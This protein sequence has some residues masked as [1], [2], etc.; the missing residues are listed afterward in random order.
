MIAE[1]DLVVEHFVAHGTHRGSV[2]GESPTGR[3]VVLRGINIFRIATAR[4]P[5]GGDGSTILGC[6]S[7]DS[8][9]HRPWRRRRHEAQLKVP[10]CKSLEQG[11]TT[12]R[13]NTKVGTMTMR[14]VVIGAGWAGEGHV[15]GLRDAG[16]EVVALFGRTPEPAF[17]TRRS[18]G[19]H[20]CRL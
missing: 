18:A 20:G 16:V 13:Q 5:N 6:S 11:I 10:T 8:C 9:R 15:I 12:G 7:S 4:S 17:S 2:M 3:D 14:A 1:D 19:D